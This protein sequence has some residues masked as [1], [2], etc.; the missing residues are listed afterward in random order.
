[1]TC[2]IRLVALSLLA[3]G[4]AL[5]QS[6]ARVV[7]NELMYN[8][9]DDSRQLERLDEE[10]LELHNLTDAPISLRGWY[11]DSG[12][13][14]L[15]PDLSLPAKGFLVVARNPQHFRDQHPG[16]LL[17]GPYEGSLSNS[18][19]KLRL[20]DSNGRV[21]DEIR[22]ADQGAFATRS[23][24][25]NR[26]LDDWQ[27]IS[28]SDGEGASLERV[29]PRLSGQLGAN[30]RSSSHASGTPGQANSQASDDAAPLIS[31]LS[32][33][34]VVPRSNQ[35]VT[36][37]AKIQDEDSVAS[38]GVFFRLDGA[39]EFASVTMKQ[40]GER[41][42]SILPPQ[43]DKAIVE[44]FVQASDAGGKVRQWPNLQ[45]DKPGM[46]EALCLYQVDDALDF[47]A[48]SK[49]GAKPMYRLIA[50]KREIELLRKLNGMSSSDDNYDSRVNATFLS[51]I[52]GK[53][54]CNYLTSARIRGHGSRSEFPPNLRVTFPRDAPWR[55]LDVINLNTQHT[56]SQTI[57]YAIH[58]LA[59]MA[60]YRTT[61]VKVRINGED[62]A[63]S[64]SP[65]FGHYVHNEVLN[66]EFVANH[67][68]DEEGSLYRVIGNGNFKSLGPKAESYR[69]TYNLRN[70]VSTGD[71]S[72][73]I[74]FISVLDQ[75]TSPADYLAQVAKVTD[76]DQWARYFATDTLLCNLEGGLP[77]GRGDDVALFRGAD[78]RFQL[79]PYDMDS[80]LGMGERSLNIQKS[81]MDYGNVQGFRLL[82]QQVEFKQ[83]YVAAIR[84]LLDTVYKPEVLYPLIE[85][86]LSD[87]VPRD[88]IKK[89]KD[90]IPKRAAAVRRQIETS[91]SL[92]CSLPKE[93]GYYKV[94]KTP[95]ALYGRYDAA[96]TSEFTISGLKPRL[97][98]S[99]GT[100]F[101]VLDPAKD[102]RS[103]GIHRL[104]ALKR[105]AQGREQAGESLALWM[106]GKV[107]RIMT[108][109]L[110]ESRWTAEGGPYLLDGS[111][112]IPSGITLTIEPG[113]TVFTN[114]EAR[115]I[116]K[117]RLKAE[118]TASQKISFT[119]APDSNSQVLVIH[120]EG[121]EALIRHAHLEDLAFSGEANSLALED[122]DWR[123]NASGFLSLRGNLSL[124][125]CHITASGTGQSFAKL[126]GKAALSHNHITAIGF[127]AVLDCSACSEVRI[128]GNRFGGAQG[129]VIRAAPGAYVASNRFEIPASGSSPLVELSSGFAVLV[130][131]NY[132]ATRE[133][134]RAGASIL[135][136]GNGPLSSNE[137]SKAD[138]RAVIRGLPAV[139]R[140]SG[141]MVELSGPGV[142]QLRYRIDD[143]PWSE[144]I[145]LRDRSNP[146]GG[147]VGHALSLPELP[148][149]EHI[150]SVVGQ[151]YLGEWQA[152]DKATTAKWRVDPN[153]FP[154]RLNEILAVNSKAHAIGDEF[155]DLIE[156]HNESDMEL[157]LVGVSLSDDKR[158]AAKYIFPEGARLGARGY[159]VLSAV[160]SAKRGGGM[161]LPFSLS[162]EGDSLYLFQK[163]G[164]LVDS[165]EFGP[166][167][168]DLS[169]GR[170]PDGSWRL[171]PP[172]LGQ[173]NREVELADASALRISE[174]LAS[175]GDSVQDDFV[176]LANGADQ[177]VALVGL[178]LTN[179]LG[180]RKQHRPMPAHGF[181]GPKSALSFKA[182]GK[183][184]GF[185][186]ALEGDVLGLLR[187]GRLIDFAAYPP[188][189][190]G[191]SQ[192]RGEGGKWS[193][194]HEPTPGK[195]SSVSLTKTGEELAKLQ[196][197]EIHY[198]PEDDEA[199]FLE[200]TNLGGTPMDLAGVRLRGG[201]RFA[202]GSMTLEP[203]RSLVL[204]KSSTAFAKYHGDAV[205]PAGEYEGKLSN[206]RDS[207][208][209]ETADGSAISRVQYSDKWHPRTDG[210]GMSLEWQSGDGSAAEDW[211]ASDQTDGTPGRWQDKK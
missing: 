62:W 160:K 109:K 133:L 207:L 174:I 191:W 101:F 187:E 27:W 50:P 96:N 205:K 135:S 116:V 38:A 17:A 41:W 47:A 64:G 184:L 28:P 188:Q 56:H 86:V 73:L 113:V 177:P 7:I 11:F 53:L 105:D 153:H 26:G 35:P 110:A 150:L 169:L 82:F 155:P 87:W 111:T 185:K 140:S 76:L 24:G 99:S 208:R 175:G 117:G 25:Q 2:L 203:Q 36:I 143:R 162:A 5:S 171:G 89:I 211:K 108:G 33:D 161:A 170:T 154:L 72:D 186:L 84:D 130:N 58:R 12:I 21:V 126:E 163:G 88:E 168:S 122:L 44:F 167:V 59:G 70:D 180:Q 102:L 104:V 94:D 98:P 146:L 181:I 63:N 39:S 61:P 65:Q 137:N 42:V 91:A 145:T 92:A 34:P 31:E 49:P 192:V 95:F 204:V 193:Y 151:G 81:I 57:G 136:E 85:E 118:G 132:P 100:W 149:G 79:V 9:G 156:L 196:I 4:T 90:F 6:P 134:F 14:C 179:N 120:L 194:S 121:G 68:G 139:V 128:V 29:N 93:H 71:Y 197:T 165:V 200:I 77:T 55:G 166:Q 20:R 54:E 43:A 30:W 83:R 1:M 60:S 18:G 190:P 119:H 51:I 80:I 32:H 157:D 144:E 67:F 16:L 48:L 127:D 173:A 3:L 115:L 15:L 103:P 176:E 202:F 125:R 189:V 148:A 75:R 129:T 159:L 201:V 158:E 78:G 37:S 46:A 69:R 141:T 195:L 74:E 66:D 45:A 138:P 178:V 172:T 23:L 199:E 152:E 40:E 124:G 19:E 206:S 131:N 209:L 97:N 22:Y 198:H 164:E 114:P 123:N 8:A 107:S 52:G 112:E 147:N 182:S 183:E 106:P 142:F 13:R 10:F 210:K